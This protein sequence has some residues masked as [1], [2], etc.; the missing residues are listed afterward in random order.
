[1][2][3]SV[4]RLIAL[5]MAGT[6][7][8]TAFVPT[9]L[10]V[11]NK[12][13]KAKSS[14]STGTSV[15]DVLSASDADSYALLGGVT[16]SAEQSTEVGNAILTGL[17]N[18]ETEID[19]SEYNVSVSAA[20]KAAKTVLKDTNS[21]DS[22]EASVEKG[23]NGKAGVVSLDVDPLTASVIDEMNNGT[24]SKVITE[25]STGDV[26]VQADSEE[27]P[28]VDPENPDPE[29]P[30][31][32]N[33]DPENP[34]PENPDPG[35]GDTEKK[36]FTEEQK[37][38]LLDDWNKYQASIT[39]DNAQYFGVQV[40]YF[41]T[42]DTTPNPVGSLMSIARFAYNE[43][44]DYYY[45][46]NEDGSEKVATFDDI[47]GTVTMFTTANQMAV[48]MFGSELLASR[49]E[50]LACL[51]DDM[52]TEQKLLALND[53]LADKAQFDMAYLMKV[54]AEEP[55]E[56]PYRATIADQIF[57]G[58]KQQYADYIAAGYITEEELKAQAE[59]VADNILGL[60]EGQQFGILCPSLGNIGVCMGYT[61]AYNYLVQN[62]FS[63]IYKNTDGSWKTFQE[64]NYNDQKNDKGEYVYQPKN[65]QAMV[66]TV[67]IDF[68]SDVT[69]YGEVKPNFA[70]E[71]YWSAVQV[72]GEWY[73]ID[74]CYNDIWIE[75]MD[76]DRVEFDGY[77]NHLFFLI[78]DASTQSMFDG[79]YTKPLHTLYD[80]TKDSSISSDKTYEDAW[81]AYAK[82]NTTDVNGTWYYLYDSTDVLEQMNRFSNI[83]QTKG[84]VMDMNR[85]QQPKIRLVSHDGSTKDKTADPGLTT[86]YINFTANLDDDNEDNDDTARVT[87][88]DPSS[89]EMKDNKELTEL[90]T[91]QKDYEAKYPSVQIC[92][93][94][95]ADNNLF[96]FNIANCIY[97]Y[98]TKTGDVTRV[99]EYNAVGAARDKS[100][101]MVGMAL[102]ATAYGADDADLN[103]ENPPIAG[104]TIKNGKLV[105]SLATNYAFISSPGWR[106][107]GDIEE[108]NKNGHYGYEFEETNYNSSY[109][110]FSRFGD[111]MSG[112]LEQMGYKQETND[113]QEFMWTANI[114]DTVSMS[115]L[116]GE[117]KYVEVK[118][119]P[120]C[121]RDGYTENRCETCGAI[122]PDS[123]KYDEGTALK[124]HYIKFDETYYTKDK[125]SG[126]YNTGTAYICTICKD[127]QKELPEGYEAGHD[128]SKFIFNWKDDFTCE[129]AIKTCD[130]CYGKTLDLLASN[131]GV[132]NF[133]QKAD[134]VEVT[135][136][137][138][139]C[140]T[141]YTATA[142]FGD[143]TATDTKVDGEHKMTKVDEVA[144]TC[145]KDGTKEYYT[146]SE[147]GGK[148]LDEKGETKVEK[149]EDLVIK[150]T[151]HDLEKV[152]AK[153]ATCEEDGNNEYYTCKNCDK[154]F[155]DAE[156]KTET[157]VEAETIKA[158]GHVLEKVEAKDATCEEAGNNEYYK[159][160]NCDKVFKDAEGKT[161]TTVKDETIKALDHQLT[162]VAAKPA[163][164]EADGNEA[165]YVCDNC[166][167]AFADKDAT[168]EIKAEDQ[169]I[170]KIA[171]AETKSASYTYT[172]KS[173][174]PTVN[175]Y[176][177]KGELIA[178][179]N[180]TLSYTNGRKNVGTHDIVITFNG[181]KYDGTMNV[182]YVIKP[183]ATKNL[184]LTAGSKRF[185]AKWNKK[186]PQVTGYQLQYSR[187]SS[188]SKRSN[189]WIS[190]YKTTSATV[191]KLSAKKKYYVRVRTYKTVDG[192]KYYSSW[193]KVKT[194]TTKK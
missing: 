90:Y 121:G 107:Q 153:D 98:N 11:D 7:T 13:T 119:D 39:G 14:A 16:E 42:Q 188:F 68:N 95:D 69:M 122:E 27:T 163:T 176:D 179:T 104:V 41:T 116:Q 53:W 100:I 112:M 72:G 89:K 123:R 17:V 19:V 35:T 185:T 154:V 56:N 137:K 190:S 108:G 77:V 61:Y 173:K 127:S 33:P 78:S 8:T 149:D 38:K 155:K 70:T 183:A 169:T 125:N 75:C 157:T 187:Y 175:V 189:K 142:T 87:V 162:E 62:A 167:K 18:G 81:F 23:D 181:K 49:D 74:S 59:G 144:A 117:H 50:A 150:A 180:Y 177:S 184:K 12:S 178:D 63:D 186:S 141:A 43:E 55:K 124:H 91:L 58:L 158:T 94:Y 9:V 151:G 10:A 65:T 82:S 135:S 161:E 140:V 64:V 128:L 3:Q 93:D 88:L 67:K 34:D 96:Y 86:T 168:K 139:G 182:S 170:A 1:M 192:T 134:K 136:A 32:E 152:E 15:S 44:G 120:T 166:K 83:G 160:K 113:N 25:E 29:N 102:T 143:K 110:D 26:A 99:K 2:K 118:V 52:S 159:C 85:Q 193:A 171:S 111:S 4:K 145:D 57:Q 47:D 147:C 101:Q 36:G 146:C 20:N 92:A 105:V 66:D 71:H 48:G 51:K 79:N 126:E 130:T 97:T 115:D 76:R 194:V 133:S 24:I 80:S 138:D 174:S 148:Y 114:V 40:P 5:L 131:D 191:K 45:S 164:A 103:V 109:V 22:V 54:P 37:A 132:D 84:T 156:G 73:Y 30:D 165:Y 172:G 129:S 28:T 46:L 6:I 106:Y 21:T 31:P 60:W